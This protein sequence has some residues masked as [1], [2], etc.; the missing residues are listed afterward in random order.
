M[1][2]P[3]AKTA[4]AGRRRSAARDLAARKSGVKAGAVQASYQ[5]LPYIEQDNIGAASV[6]PD[7][8]PWRWIP[9]IPASLARGEAAP[10]GAAAVVVRLTGDAFAY[11]AF[12]FSFASGWRTSIA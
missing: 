2:K 10:G 12:R 1:G 4:K 7:R 5:L 9:A 11:A 6:G 3:K 8:L